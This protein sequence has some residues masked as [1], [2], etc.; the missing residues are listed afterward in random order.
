RAVDVG[1]PVA[2]G[3]HAQQ[4]ELRPAAPGLEALGDGGVVGGLAARDVLRVVWSVRRGVVRV[5]V[6]L[7]P[8]QALQRPSTARPLSVL[9]LLG[10]GLVGDP[11]VG[12]L[13]FP[14]S[15][16][17]GGGCGLGAELFVVGG[18]ASLRVGLAALEVTGA[19]A[20]DAPLGPG[21]FVGGADDGE[22]AVLAQVLLLRLLGLGLLGHSGL[23]SGS[24]VGWWCVRLSWSCAP[25]PRPRA[26]E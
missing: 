26:G 23:P 15:R 13:L 12:L 5:G 4:P 11:L 18:L 16:G 22:T 10:L 24:S 25:A 3:V 14:R 7:E 21:A 8:P 2:R 9:G 20:L 6:V 1:H 17:S 19:L